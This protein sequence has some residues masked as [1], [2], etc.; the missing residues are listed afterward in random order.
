M[1]FAYLIGSE[2]IIRAVVEKTFQQSLYKI[3][4]KLCFS[5]SQEFI[6]KQKSIDKPDIILI[7]TK[8]SDSTCID[9]AII[10]RRVFPQV[11]ILFLGRTPS[12]EL[13]DE[14][15]KMNIS[16]LERSFFGWLIL[17]KLIVEIIR[18]SH[19]KKSRLLVL[20]DSLQNVNTSNPKLPESKK[21]GLTDQQKLVMSLRHT[22][23][24]YG[25]IAEILNISRSSVQKHLERAKNKINI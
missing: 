6:T 20:S 23:A 7:Y 10:C 14:S 18:N 5:S 16:I 19:L 11:P 1:I 17:D 2:D 21:K 12:N 25:K 8:L 3:S 9:M 4:L 15:K 24:S 22:G 13:I